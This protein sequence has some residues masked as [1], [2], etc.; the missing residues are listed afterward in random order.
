V[1][2]DFPFERLTVWQKTRTLTVQMYRATESFPK[3]EMFGLTGQIRRAAVSIVA[4]IAEGS[5][6]H[7]PAVLANHLDI[8]IGSTAE[9]LALIQVAEDVGYLAEEHGIPLR[10]VTREVSRMLQALHGTIRRKL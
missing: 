2:D 9:L 8:A 4:N 5:A 3:S 1:A 6:R 10:N 7:T